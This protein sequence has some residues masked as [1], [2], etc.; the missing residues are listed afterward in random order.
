MIVFGGAA[1]SS[2]G[3]GYGFGEIDDPFGLLENAFDLGITTYDTAPIYGFGESERVLGEAFL[4]NREKVKIISKA[5]VGWHDNGRVNMSNEPRL[6]LKM[7]EDSLRRLQSDY[8][9]IYMIHWPDRNVD[10]RYPLEVLLKAQIQGKIHS[11]GLCNTNTLDLELS[12][13]MA[14]IEFVQSEF[15][16]FN[17]GFS[18]L[19]VGDFQKMGWGTFDKGIL[20]GTVK[21]DRKFSK[22]DCRSW[23]PWW[24]KSGWKEKVQYVEEFR[25][26]T[27]IKS[28]ALHFS[29]QNMDM[30]LVGIKNTEQLGEIIR[31]S[32]LNLDSEHILDAQKYFSKFRP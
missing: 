18:D 15:N 2:K 1:L 25:D 22:H 23:A 20:A 6:V 29:L 9:D 7:L 27:N 32:Y 19:P 24:K 17:D 30:T 3:G 4:K 10:I 26:F 13:E 11:I 8:I 31:L 5:G 21:A 28:L 12:S 14:N 16:F